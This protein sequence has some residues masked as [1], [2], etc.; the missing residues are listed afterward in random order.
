VHSYYRLKRHLQ[1]LLQCKIFGNLVTKFYVLLFVEVQ[2]KNSRN[3]C[4]YVQYTYF[5]TMCH[6]D[7]SDWIKCHKKIISVY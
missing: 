7:A 4:F 5:L 2:S 1:F 3:W 6:L